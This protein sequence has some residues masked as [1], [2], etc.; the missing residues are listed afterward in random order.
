MFISVC[1][2]Q[3]TETEGTITYSIRGPC[4]PKHR[5]T[6]VKLS[7]RIVNVMIIVTHCKKLGK[8]DKNQKLRLKFFNLKGNSDEAAT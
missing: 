7:K 1:L 4:G 6:M 5:L 3:R 2:C 8:A